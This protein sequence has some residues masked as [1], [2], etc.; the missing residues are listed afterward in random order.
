M[1]LVLPV[2]YRGDP[3]KKYFLLGPTVRLG[4]L[5]VLMPALRAGDTGLIPGPGEN[6]YSLN[7]LIYDLPERYS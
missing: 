3:I 4:G 2:G 6:F 7:L 5:V 1:A